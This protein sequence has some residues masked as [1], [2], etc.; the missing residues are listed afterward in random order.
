LIIGTSPVVFCISVGA[1]FPV[2]LYGACSDLLSGTAVPRSI[3]SFFVIRSNP[4][5]V[6]VLMAGA[7]PYL[8][9]YPVLPH[10][11]LIF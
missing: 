7:F 11:Y 3:D 5:I 10:K 9:R 4:G 6:T 1:F 2:G 8:S